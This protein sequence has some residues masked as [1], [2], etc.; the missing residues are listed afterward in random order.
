MVNQI[1]HLMEIVRVLD[2]LIFLG[3]TIVFVFIMFLLLKRTK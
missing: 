3:I 2:D 1:R